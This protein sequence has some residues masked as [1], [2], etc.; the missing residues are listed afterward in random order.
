MSKNVHHEVE[1]AAI[2]GKGGK[3]I[4]LEEALSHVMGY[5][6]LLDITARDLQDKYIAEGRPWSIAKG[7][8]TFAPMKLDIVPSEQIPDPDNLAIS[9]TVNGKVRQNSSTKNMI[10]SVAEQISAISKITTLERGDVIATGTPEGVGPIE[11]GDELFASIESVGTL[12]VTAV[13]R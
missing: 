11:D 5:T 1:L 9:L 8:D 6:I 10:F 12:R 3:D 13:R 2:I 7:F 4:P